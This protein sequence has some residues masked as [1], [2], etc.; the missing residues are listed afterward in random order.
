MW[1]EAI[2]A[3]LQAIKRKKDFGLTRPSFRPFAFSNVT[4]SRVVPYNWKLGMRFNKIFNCRRKNTRYALIAYTR[5]NTYSYVRLRWYSNCV[6]NYFSSFRGTSPNITQ[7]I[8]SHMLR[9]IYPKVV[10][11]GDMN[12]EKLVFVIRKELETFR[13]FSYIHRSDVNVMVF[14]LLVF[15]FFE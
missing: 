4:P 6:F 12:R 3:F 15:F 10:L 13:L 14:L 7:G 5:T 11:C 2:G 9:N 8:R 1:T